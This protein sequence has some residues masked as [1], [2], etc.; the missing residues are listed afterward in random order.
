LIVLDTHAWVW[1]VA[2]PDRLSSQAREA[3]EEAR[4]R[5]ELFVSSFSVW[6]VTMLVKRGRL[7]LTSDLSDWLARSEALP[8]LTFVPVDNHVARRSVELPPPLHADPADRLI[9]AT[10]LVLGARLV[11]KDRRL[12]DYPGV[13]SVW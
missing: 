1:W 9:V 6:E 4:H 2:A 12:L 3:V 7:R 5:G 13:D 11:T 8:F 10:T